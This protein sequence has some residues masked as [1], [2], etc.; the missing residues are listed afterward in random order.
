MSIADTEFLSNSLEFLN[1]DLHGKVKMVLVSYLLQ[2]S[3]WPWKA[4]TVLRH[5]HQAL[6]RMIKDTAHI[7]V[8]VWRIACVRCLH[9]FALMS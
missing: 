4:A 5:P 7:L 2:E 1:G 3:F 9:A 6:L 8:C